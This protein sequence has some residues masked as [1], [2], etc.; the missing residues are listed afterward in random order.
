MQACHFFI[1]K[2]MKMG[3]AINGQAGLDFEQ[4]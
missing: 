3:Q 1:K 4:D 2:S